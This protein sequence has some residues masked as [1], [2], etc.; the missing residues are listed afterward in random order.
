MKECGKMIYSM[1]KEQRLG[2]IILN[3]KENIKTVKNM[4]KVLIIIMMVPNIKEIG[5]KTIYLA[6]VFIRGQM[7]E[8]M[9][10]NG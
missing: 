3:M 4:D 2:Q 10:V 6:M 8:N 5:K 9:K 7:E 1:V